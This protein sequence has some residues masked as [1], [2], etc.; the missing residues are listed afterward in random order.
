MMKSL[1][2]KAKNDLVILTHNKK[3]SLW[4]SAI[5]L[6]DFYPPPADLIF[7][8]LLV[9]LSNSPSASR[10]FSPERSRMGQSRDLFLPSPNF[11]LL[12]KSPSSKNHHKKIL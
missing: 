11:C 7:D 10:A 2:S 5:L 4:D 8:F 12:T 1:S 9:N 6:F 3:S